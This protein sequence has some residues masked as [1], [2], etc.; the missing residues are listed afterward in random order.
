M[1]QLYYKAVIY[2]DIYL[3]SLTNS[4]L[5]VACFMFITMSYTILKTFKILRNRSCLMAAITSRISRFTFTTE[6]ERL[7]YTRSSKYSHRQQ[8]GTASFGE[9]ICHKMSP[10]RDLT[11]GTDCEQLS[12]SFEQCVQCL[13]LTGKYSLS[14]Y[15]P[16]VSI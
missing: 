5:T 9:S 14:D 10:T 3:L 4:I 6:Y 7:R 16:S 11:D 13:Q 12:H 2:Y 8:F 1:P 15:T